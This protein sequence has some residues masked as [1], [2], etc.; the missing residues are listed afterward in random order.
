MKRPN[1]I[2]PRTMKPEER[3]AELFNLLAQGCGRLC[4]AESDNTETLATNQP[5]PTTQYA[6]TERSSEHV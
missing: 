3:L 4:A 6:R 2:H 1:P 5:F